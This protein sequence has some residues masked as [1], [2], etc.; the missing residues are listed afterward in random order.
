[1]EGLQQ[2]AFFSDNKFELNKAPNLLLSTW[3]AQLPRLSFSRV[4]SSS[5]HHKLHAGMDKLQ[6]W[7]SSWRNPL[8]RSCA[9]CAALFAPRGLFGR[10]REQPQSLLSSNSQCDVAEEILPHVRTVRKPATA[11]GP[12]PPETGEA[13]PWASRL[14]FAPDLPPLA[15]PSL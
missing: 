12:A 4:R 1:M 13:Q 6:S 15:L 10:P 7:A 3:S 5:G 14:R 11:A 2:T 8:A 9:A